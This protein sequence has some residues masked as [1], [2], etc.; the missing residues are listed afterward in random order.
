[1]CLTT[2]QC[3]DDVCCQENEEYSDDEDDQTTSQFNFASQRDV[4]L[5]ALEMASSPTDLFMYGVSPG[6]K[7][8]H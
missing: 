7:T 2:S 5:K 3:Y 6:Y 1:M 4:S 8:A